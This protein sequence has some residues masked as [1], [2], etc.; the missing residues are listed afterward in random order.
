MGISERHQELLNQK[1]HFGGK[2]KLLRYGQPG[3]EKPALLDKNNQIRDVTGIIPDVAD[4][5][6]SPRSLERL[7]TLIPIASRSSPVL[8]ASVPA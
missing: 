3:K 5:V 8:R 2:M 6:L 4:E 7:A 1:T